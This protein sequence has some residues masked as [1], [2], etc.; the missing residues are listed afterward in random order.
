MSGKQYAEMMQRQGW[1]PSIPEEV[2]G[3]FCAELR[4]MQ[5]RVRGQ[6]NYTSQQ[7]RAV[8]VDI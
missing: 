5:I 4:R 2:I 8:R 6:Y 3:E 7:W 1:T